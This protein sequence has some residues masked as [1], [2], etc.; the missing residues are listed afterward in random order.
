[1]NEKNDTKELITLV[2]Q[3]TLQIKTMQKEVHKELAKLK[4]SNDVTEAILP[5]TEEAISSLAPIDEMKEFVEKFILPEYKESDGYS[6]TDYV[7]DVIAPV[8]GIEDDFNESIITDENRDNNIICKLM[9]FVKGMSSDIFLMQKQLI[10]INNQVKDM[11]DEQVKFRTSDEYRKEQASKIEALKEEAKACTDAIQHRKIDKMIST[12]ESLRTYDFLLERFDKYGE[13]EIQQILDGFFKSQ[14]GKYIMDKYKSKAHLFNL[15]PDG[16][17]RYFNFE[18]K[19]LEE[20]YHP[21]NNLLLFVFMRFVSYADSSNKNDR[22]FVNAFNTGFSNTVYHRFGS[23]DAKNEF[24]DAMRKIL[25]HF[26][27]KSDYF[28]EHN[29]S[30]PM[31]ENRIR[32]EKE[33]D[34]RR[35]ESLMKKLNNL[36]VE[37]SDDMT[38]DEL[39]NLYN[40]TIDKF[41]DEMAE[42]SEESTN[43]PKKDENGVL[44]VA[45]ELPKE[46]TKEE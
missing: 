13:K 30:A 27:D 18:E 35:R 21:F 43:I 8:V 24:L 45:P 12:M 2:N 28:T 14:K 25:D 17:N 44:T 19:F 20:K 26:L 11:V 41:V 39:Q 32:I 22:M 37:V 4:L 1:M 23:E 5:Y 6:F 31:N 29:T 34:A 9:R 33:H 15:V 38:T 40:D 42:S 16:Y 7:K 10:E 36:E 3:L 46:E